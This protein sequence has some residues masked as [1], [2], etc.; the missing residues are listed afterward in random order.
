M[1]GIYDGIEG[2]AFK[3]IEGGYVYQVNNR[4]LIGPR[5]RFFVTEA[6]K[7]DLAACMRETL[8][9][10]K[11]FVL[12]TA[13]GLPA[14]ITGLI[15]WFVVS[16]ATLTVIVVDRNGKIES[17]EQAIGRHGASGTLVAADGSSVAYRV[18]G[19]PGPDAT[20]TT[21]V[22]MASGKVGA[23]SVVPFD[24]NGTIIKMA[25]STKHIVRAASL[26]GRR[27][28]TMTAGMLFAFAVS[29]GL[30]A[31]YFAA[32]HV[33]SMARL[34]PLLTGLP[35]TDE[36]IGMREGFDRFAANIST[37]LLAVMGFGAVATVIGGVLSTTEFFL[38]H[39]PLEQLPFRLVPGVCALI[40]AAQ[41]GYLLV[42][43]L[44]Q[45]RNG[46]A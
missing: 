42:R 45:R 15:Y 21:T 33:Y 2:V 19:A 27:G 10:L 25:D 12:A 1:A 4:W 6:Q 37:K 28:P 38:T 23:T 29:L 8:R 44:R 46:A 14:A 41:V 5:G 9:R 11:P 20:A 34:H 3:R 16:S 31:L 40:V 36:R 39:R 22:I 43:R 30:F 24:T 13:I 7:A 35:R 26:A 32:I 17:H 18:S